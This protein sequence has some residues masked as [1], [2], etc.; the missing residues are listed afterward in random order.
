MRSI[1][2]AREADVQRSAERVD[3]VQIRLAES[4][5]AEKALKDKYWWWCRNYRTILRNS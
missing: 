3:A 5:A 2:E 4:L 1:K